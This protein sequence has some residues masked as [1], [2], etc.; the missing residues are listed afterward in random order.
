MYDIIIVGAGYA[1]AVSAR[2]LAEKGKRVL[3]IE[4]RT[5][6]GGNAYDELDEQG[7]LIHTYGPHIF[8]TK[9]KAVFD[10]LGR[11]TEWIP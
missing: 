6:I 1:G 7:V 10:F 11:F 9:N 4:E 3:V 5:H 2:R 8:H